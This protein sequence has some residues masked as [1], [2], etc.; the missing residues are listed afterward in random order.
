M[1]LEWIRR[2]HLTFDEELKDFL[3]TDKLITH[4]QSLLPYQKEAL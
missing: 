4:K 3:L 2:E 1:V